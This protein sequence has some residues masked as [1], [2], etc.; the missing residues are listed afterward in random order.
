MSFG[1]RLISAGE[2]APSITT[3]SF[4]AMSSCSARRTVGQA[5]SPRSRQGKAVSS[6]S[7]RPISTYWLCV[8]ASGLSSTGFMRT[9]GSARAASA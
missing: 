5:R 4:S 7:T 8:S 2:P 3:T 9:S 1:M 6:A